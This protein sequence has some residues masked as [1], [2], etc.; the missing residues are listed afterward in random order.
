ME[1]TKR[2]FNSPSKGVLS[3][4][5]LCSEITQYVQESP[6]DSYSLVIGTDS[7]QGEH[8]EFITAIV[9]HR[10][11]R[12]GRYFWTRLRSPRFNSL[13]ERIWQEAFLSIKIALRLRELLPKEICSRL[14]IHADVGENGLTRN[15]I[16]EVTGMITGNGFKPR[17]KPDAYAATAVADRHC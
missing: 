2:T 13:R 3:E 9:M 10:V 17:I 12:G 1:T 8:V 4:K 14:E 15:L 6:D 7:E 11:G 16:N 5:E